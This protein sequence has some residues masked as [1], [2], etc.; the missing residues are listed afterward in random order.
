M[1]K[2]M[3]QTDRNE[4]TRRRA[5]AMIRRGLVEGEGDS[6]T[7]AFWK[8]YRDSQ[9][10][11]SIGEQEQQDAALREH[12]LEPSRAG[13]SIS[14]QEEL[15]EDPRMAP[16]HSGRAHGGEPS[17]GGGKDYRT[18]Q[19]LKQAAISGELKGF[20]DARSVA[21]K[22]TYGKG[23]PLYPNYS[24]EELEA[25]PKL[26][27]LKELVNEA[28]K[29]EPTKPYVSFVSDEYFSRKPSEAKAVEAYTGYGTG[30]F[31]KA[32]QKNFTLK[33]GMNR[34]KN[35]LT[36]TKYL[37]DYVDEEEELYNQIQALKGA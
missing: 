26:K 5:N 28:A 17:T 13:L 35:V 14:E 30:T 11:L 3:W 6:E 1:P 19:Y 34:P 12:G 2:I 10:G 22:Q 18:D 25:N 31:I 8:A 24:H 4:M 37:D 32:P 9:A 21:Y 23:G 16:M 27:Q 29:Q 15:P 20:K 36:N 7:Q 33:G